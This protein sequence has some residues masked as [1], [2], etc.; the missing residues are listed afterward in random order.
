MYSPEDLFISPCHAGELTA[1]I[2]ES[3]IIASTRATESTILN[4]VFDWNP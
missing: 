2:S 1:T 3:F 4:F